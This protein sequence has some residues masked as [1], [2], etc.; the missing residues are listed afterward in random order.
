MGRI[1]DLQE[2]AT[3]DR[4]E[5]RLTQHT[6]DLSIEVSNLPHVCDVGIRV[7]PGDT[8]SIRSVAPQRDIC[9]SGL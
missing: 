3:S 8:E 9:T 1:P 7:G 4:M 5:P 2:E 6:N